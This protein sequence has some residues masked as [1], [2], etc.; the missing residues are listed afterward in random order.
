LRTLCGKPAALATF[1]TGLSVNRPDAAL[2]RQAGRGLAWLH[3]AAAGYQGRR[4]NTLG[5]PFWAPMFAPLKTAAEGLK[6]G[7]AAT[8][9]QD[10][11][12]L[13]ERWPFDLPQGTIHADF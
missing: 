1:L 7:L 6:P 8:I 2:C 12:L 5:Q 4:V 11:A 10:L 13:A 3:E 9:D